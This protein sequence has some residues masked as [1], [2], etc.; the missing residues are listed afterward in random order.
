MSL[1]YAP[2]STTKDPHLLQNLLMRKSRLAPTG[3]ITY[4]LNARDLGFQ[5]WV[6]ILPAPDCIMVEAP[7]NARNL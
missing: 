4:L 2:I 1:I 6:D 7:M 5:E 3:A